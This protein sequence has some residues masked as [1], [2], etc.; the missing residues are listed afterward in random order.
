MKKITSSGT[1]KSFALNVSYKKMLL[2]LFA[3]VF[4]STNVLWSQLYWNTNGTGA[5]INTANWASTSAGPFTSVWVGGSDMNFTANS[6]I[7]YV[8]AIPIG[9]I[10]ISD[11]FT[12]TITAAGTL[13][14]G[15][16]VKTINVG[17]GSTLTWNG[18]GVS[19]VAGTGFIKSGNGTWNI[20]A[21]ANAY[22]GGFTL[23]AGTVILGG[24]NALGAGGALTINGGTIAATAARDLSG[25]FTGGIIVG[26]DFQLGSIVS[27][28]VGSSNLT[29]TNN[30]DLGGAT[31]N[32]AIGGSGIYTFGGIISNGGITLN[33]ASGGTV[34]LSGVNTYAGSTTLNG[35]TLKLNPSGNTTNTT[36]FVL[37]GGI[38]STS[39]ITATRT[40][41]ASTLQLTNNTTLDLGAN[42][43]TL[44]FAASDAVVW[45]AN[46]KLIISGWAGTAGN[47][48]TVGKLFVGNSATGLTVDQLSQIRFIGYPSAMLLSTGELVPSNIASSQT[49]SG[50]YKVGTTEVSPN[51][52]SLADAVF[53][54]NSSNITGNVVL[55]ISSDLTEPENIGLGVN[56][57][58]FNITIRPDVVADPNTDPV[59]TITFTQL[60]DNLSPTGHLVIG[61]PSAGLPVAW[62]ISNT[63]ATN[64]VTID[65]YAVGGTTK[66]LK[67]TNSNAAITSTSTVGARVIV[68]VGACQNTT[69]KNC[70]V[71]NK[72]TNTG[73]P[74]CI[75]AVVRKVGTV[76][77]DA[78]LAPNGL[79]LDNNTITCTTS[80]VG[81][82]IRITNSNTPLTATV[83]GFVCKNN[84]I[85]AQRRILEM[86][87]TNGGQIYGNTISLVQPTSTALG[88]GIWTAT[89]CAGTFNIYNNKIIAASC[90]G[91]DVAAGGQRLMSLGGSVTCNVYN[92]MFAG[93]DRS[94]TTTAAVNQTYCFFGCTGKIYNN[95]FYMPALTVK[96]NTGYY[97]AIQLSF[98]NPDIKNN[99]FI[100]N[101]DGM[102]NAFY[103][104]VTTGASDYNVFYNRAGN[105]KSLFVS[106]TATSTFAAYQA[107]YPTKDKNSKNVDVN[108]VSATDLTPTG[109]SIGDY[110]L[111]VPRQASVLTDI[112]GT[113]RA[114]L[115]Y[116]G[117]FEASDLTTVAKQFTVTVPNGTAHVYIAGDFTGK[118]WDN[119]TPF[120]L[121]P[122]GT[123]NQFSGIFPCVDGVA[124]KYLCEKT[125]DW[126]YAEAVY[127]GGNAPLLG[128]NRTYN[129]AD[130]VP[131]W[132]RVK[133]VQFNVSFGAGTGI[134][135]QLFVK[136]SWDVWAT[137]IALTQSGSTFSTT[138]SGI[139][140]DK[141]P[142][143]TEYKYYTNDGA[144]GNWESDATGG[145]ISNRW[146][147]APIMKDVVA[148]FTTL[149]PITRLNEIETAPRIIRTSSGIEVVVDS[150]STI[151]LY[152]INGVLI[153]RTNVSGSYSHDLNN[154][155]Y[156]V[157][158]NGKATKFVK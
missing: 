136:G 73:S 22:I 154:G 58:G 17:T 8:T 20:G 61:Y 146:S 105:T 42:A 132:F 78:E 104:A 158:V 63:I 83:A 51:F 59:R 12:V 152:G 149:L 77:T 55:E 67:I 7:T 130:N 125:G 134:P 11:G 147:I 114:A 95:T 140:S 13:S 19:T 90:S 93:M 122:T 156:I 71:E 40:I 98:S 118:A 32:I 52:T 70:I 47:S 106:G 89:G 54:L 100:S 139:L 10:N 31:R 107:A 6:A 5:A 113:S 84:I 88:Y 69:I 91:A 131:I 153:D 101:E 117:A 49:M 124:Y 50:V 60:T 126:D 96:T 138:L 18:Q 28:S 143:N 65:G 92:N 14:T 48:G 129:A 116:A 127:D 45:T 30:V 112:A 43:H 145:Y 151:E 110:N 39:G 115:T 29:F 137:P 123:A 37:N 64:N 87:Y 111:A 4:L 53:A 75:V 21:Q 142:A 27:P 74:V 81:M 34:L 119:T 15:G 97:T 1:E 16:A 102:I 109:A 99:I 108:F 9:N 155:I 56:T 23:N 76:A 120:E 148:G 82:G 46:K 150:E 86:N 94:G 3:F 68:V 135:S 38:L 57:N 2:T 36:A 24:V 41:T 72:T 144:T 25:K 26:G 121:I 79:I 133:S 44:S 103:S 66:R 80:T 62:T 33:N 35:G 157:R 85:S 128:S 141:I